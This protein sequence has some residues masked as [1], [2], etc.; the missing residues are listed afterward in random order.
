VSPH[1]DFNL[2]KA[3]D[4]GL[5]RDV[6]LYLAE[7]DLKVTVTEYTLVKQ[8]GKKTL[9][10]DGYTMEDLTGG[11]SR[12]LRVALLN[13]A[14]RLSESNLAVVLSRPQDNFPGVKD[15]DSVLYVFWKKG[16][17]VLLFSFKIPAEKL[18]KFLAD[19]EI[20]L[21]GLE[22]KGHFNQILESF[23][24]NVNAAIPEDLTPGE[25]S[26]FL[27]DYQRAL[28]FAV[29]QKLKTAESNIL[30]S[31]KEIVQSYKELLD[32]A[33]N[34]FQSSEYGHKFSKVI[35][36]DVKT[37]YFGL[38]PSPNLSGVLEAASLQRQESDPVASTKLA[39]RHQSRI[40]S[41]QRSISPIS[42]IRWGKDADLALSPR[43]TVPSGLESQ[44]RAGALQV[45]G[46]ETIKAN[47]N[48]GFSD[49]K[50]QPPTNN[51]PQSYYSELNNRYFS[52]FKSSPN[53]PEDKGQKLF[54]LL[55]PQFP[56]TEAS[57]TS[58]SNSLSS[59]NGSYAE[60]RSASWQLQVIAVIETFQKVIELIKRNFASSRKLNDTKVVAETQQFGNTTYL[61]SF[62]RGIDD[63]SVNSRFLQDYKK[64]DYESAESAQHLVTQNLR[65]LKLA[66][67]TLIQRQASSF[68][69]S[70]SNVL[71]FLQRG[72]P[73]ER[74]A[75]RANKLLNY[76]KKET[77]TRAAIKQSFLSKIP[78]PK[79]LRERIKLVLR[80]FLSR[81]EASYPVRRLGDSLNLKYSRIGRIVSR[82]FAKGNLDVRFSRLLLAIR[83]AL[84]KARLHFAGK[85]SFQKVVWLGGILSLLR[86]IF[87][88]PRLAA[89]A[90]RDSKFILKLPRKFL[91][92][93]L[94]K[95]I[96]VERKPFKF[97]PKN[98]ALILGLDRIVRK[99]NQSR[100]QK[101]GKR[102]VLKVFSALNKFFRFF[103][104]FFKLIV[105][106]SGG[107][108]LKKQVEFLKLKHGVRFKSQPVNFSFAKNRFGRSKKVL[109]NQLEHKSSGESFLRV[110]LFLLFESV[111]RKA[112]L[113]FFVFFVEKIR[114]FLGQV[115]E[116]FIFYLLLKLKI[117]KGVKGLK[118][119]ILIKPTSKILKPAGGLSV[120]Q[121]PKVRQGR[122]FKNLTLQIAKV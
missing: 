121:G 69:P 38:Q 94:R 63:F 48:T 16:K 39:T 37:E 12:E 81:K 118:K 115:D 40:E 105:K 15:G 97:Y 106:K 33:K 103:T 46:S 79:V 98:K 85:K 1:F 89:S 19:A 11:V 61:A 54:S 6:A 83:I 7:E 101:F 70:T 36:I 43:S 76:V 5:A 84:A 24:K 45:R 68:S 23:A 3:Q 65:V 25:L 9:Q 57:Y 71:P 20:E 56:D 18:R 52:R 10:A 92:E 14:E 66:R 34:V 93:L 21:N 32:V 26:R 53:P 122:I 95:K 96:L 110:I 107:L 4:P 86:K 87:W 99:V 114:K 35:N 29:S 90:F 88:K 91:S 41:V 62:D 27:E 2:V 51:N 78:Q 31:I 17:K 30:E 58:N 120:S 108:N 109:Q 117:K 119:E 59:R 8:S 113:K 44:Q 74:V 49:Y 72:K 77:L 28:E 42:L 47:A 67:H 55:A 13:V 75:K 82:G 64:A 100:L 104:L 73:A 60:T 116:N 22:G 111:A 102:S 50:H 112:F 80:L